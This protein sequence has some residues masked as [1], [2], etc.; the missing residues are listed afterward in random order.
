MIDFSTKYPKDVSNAYWQ[1]K[2]SFADKTKAATKTGL[3][4]ALVT[5]E[6]AWN[7]VPWKALD[8][9]T[10]KAASVEDAKKNL[11]NGKLVQTGE[12]AKAEAALGA[13]A[14]MAATTK[15]NKALTPAARSA[16]AG[17]ELRLNRLK[18]L[19]DKLKLDDLAGEITRLE[20]ETEGKNTFRTHTIELHMPGGGH[21]ANATQGHQNKDG[22]VEIADIH[23]VGMGSIDKYKN[24]AINVRAHR[25]DGSLFTN[26]MK[27][28]TTDGKKA[29]LK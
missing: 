23:W 25:L 27:V 12:V 8:F 19:L 9:R 11:A 5:A 26:D 15:A 14:R 20:Q 13:A 22:T 24:K 16:A 29:K 28:L 18:G 2:K 6:K 4:A 10:V 21:L 1:G 17:I 7:E 3:G